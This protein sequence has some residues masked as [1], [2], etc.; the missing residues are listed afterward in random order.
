M[1]FITQLE[2]N[3]PARAAWTVLGERFGQIAEWTG[4]IETSRLIGELG[5]GAQRVCRSSQSFGP[6]PASIVTETLEEYDPAQMRFRYTAVEGIPAMFTRATN[7]WRIESLGPSRCRLTSRAELR[8]AWWATPLAP[9][10]R[11]MMRK[12]MQ[13]FER[14]LRGAVEREASAGV[15]RVA[16]CPT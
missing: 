8:M 4:S 12:P 13:E 9:L 10:V 7:L 2:L 1:E 11:V 3:T 16:A 14:E 6:F 5:V 15:E